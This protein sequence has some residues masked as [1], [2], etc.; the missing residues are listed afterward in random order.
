[1]ARARVLIVDD[2][3]FVRTTFRRILQGEFDVREEADGEAGWDAIAGDAQVACVFCDISM[4]RLDGFEVLARVRGAA[5][6]R[7]RELPVIIISGD[8]DE[9]TRRK[10][11][12]AGANDFIS[13]NADAT[14]VLARIDTVLR[15]VRSRQAAEA[16][17]THDPQ[18]GAFT[19]H[20][21]LTEGRKLFAHA[22]RH[23]GALAIISFRI[24]NH[25]RIAAEAGRPFADQLLAR[26]VK[27]IQ[28]ALRAEDTLARVGEAVFSVL[29]ADTTAPQ[30]GA[31]ARR[32]REQLGAARFKAG[33]REVRLEPSIGLAAVGTD[34]AASL[35]ELLRLA[36][37]RMQPVPAPAA[38]PAAAARAVLPA[39]LEQALRALERIPPERLAAHAAEVLRRLRPYLQALQKNAK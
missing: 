20:Y 32:L 25:A 22:R 10:A 29:L 14:E 15:M 33:E 5:E 4:P 36:S 8:E 19:L 39:E 34:A 7:I 17:A 24:D 37:G 6:A 26:I 38:A 11:R 35:E 31:F 23:G 18:T 21:L 28:G 1:M 27:A 3:K 16:S 30:A 13:K 12:E 2:S 9:A